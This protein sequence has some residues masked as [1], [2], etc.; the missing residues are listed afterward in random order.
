MDAPI[1]PVVV[2]AKSLES[3]PVTLLLKVTVKLTLAA[4]V[5][6]ALARVI[7]DTVGAT[8]STSTPVVVGGVKVSAAL[9]PSASLIVLPPLKTIGDA[10]TIPFVSLSPA[11]TV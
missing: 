4:F 7:D 11:C 8:P 5:G 1:T 10:E 3:T 6:L 9:N 2:S